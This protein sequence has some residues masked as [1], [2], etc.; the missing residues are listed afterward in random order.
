[1]LLVERSLSGEEN[2]SGKKLRLY[3][4]MTDETQ[5]EI[6]PEASGIT[7]LCGNLADWERPSSVKVGRWGF[8]IVEIEDR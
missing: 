8:A 4:N 6:M 5:M 2:I 1:M 3:I 7:L